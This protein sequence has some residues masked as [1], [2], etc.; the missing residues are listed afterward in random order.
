LPCFQNELCWAYFY[1]W[2]MEKDKGKKKIDRLHRKSTPLN[3]VVFDDKAAEFEESIISIR[4]CLF[5]GKQIQ[6]KD[7]LKLLNC[8]S[9]KPDGTY[10]SKM[11]K[12]EANALANETILHFKEHPVY[13]FNVKKKLLKKKSLDMGEWFNSPSSQISVFKPPNGLAKACQERKFI[14]YSLENLIFKVFLDLYVIHQGKPLLGTKDGCIKQIEI[15]ITDYLKESGIKGYKGYR[16]YVLA[17]IIGEK[18]GFKLF[19]GTNK[20]PATHHEYYQRVRDV[21]KPRLK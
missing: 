17:G 1:L 4:R 6:A 2:Y 18:L 21:F 5:Q 13:H 15:I 14:E 12:D 10:L 8:I 19:S 3:L 16:K 11:A 20:K 9:D 7:I